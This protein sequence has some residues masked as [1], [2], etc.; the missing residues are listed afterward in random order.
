[1]KK[2][3]LNHYI[4]LLLAILLII[5][6]S[7]GIWLYLISLNNPSL[8]D[9]N[10]VIN[11]FLNDDMFQFQDLYIEKLLAGYDVSEAE[12]L[13]TKGIRTAQQGKIKESKEIFDRARGYLKTVSVKRPPDILSGSGVSRLTDNTSPEDYP[14]TVC[15]RDG[16]IWISWLS[17]LDGHGDIIYARYFDGREWSREM[18]VSPEYGE[19]L[20]P[21]IIDEAEGGISI[22]WVDKRDRYW[23]LYGRRYDKNQWEKEEII[24]R[25]ETPILSPAVAVNKRRGGLCIAWQGYRDDGFQIYLKCRDKDKGTW[26]G[27]IL[28]TDKGSNWNP[29]LVFDQEGRLWIGWDGYQEDNYDIY[30]SSFDGKDLSKEINITI[31]P[32]Y[33]M[34]VRLAIG[35]DDQLWIVWERVLPNWN[36]IMSLQKRG[37]FNLRKEVFIC[38]K[39]FGDTS[40]YILDSSL[41]GSRYVESPELLLASDGFP[42]LLFRVFTEGEGGGR[43]WEVYRTSL[44][45]GGW[46]SPVRLFPSDGGSDRA[47]GCIDKN[48]QLWVFWQGDGRRIVKINYNLF[49]GLLLKEEIFFNKVALESPPPWP[50]LSRGRG[51]YVGAGLVPALKKVFSEEI[52]LSVPSPQ[53][54][55]GKGEGLFSEEKYHLFFGDTHVH[56]EISACFMAQDGSLEDKIR[57][58]HDV[59]GADFLSITDHTGAHTDYLW[60]KRKKIDDFFNIDGLFTTLHGYEWSHYYGHQQIIYKGDGPIIRT[61]DRR[62]NTPLELWK[63]LKGIDAIAIPHQPADK[64]F[65]YDWIPYDAELQPVVEI[66]QSHRGGYEYYNGPLS[67]DQMVKGRFVQDVLAKGYK[68]GVV[69]S[70]DHK[71]LGLTGVYAKDLSRDGIYEALK[72]RHCYATTGEKIVL[73]FR[74]DNHLMGEEYRTDSHPIIVVK[75]I[76]TSPLDKVEIIRNNREIY[77]KEEGISTISQ[78][79]FTD[80]EIDQGENFYYIRVT[81][82]DNEMAWSSPIWV[83][84]EASVSTPQP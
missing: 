37:S 57:F 4:L 70:S 84:Y 55:E 63:E 12:G 80:H 38:L 1:M 81:Q 11:T 44:I 82:K 29:S 60:H 14:S 10:L 16:N 18:Q 6:L 74:M 66:F 76:G 39:R 5:L 2:R 62:F 52:Q 28:V 72:K 77:K 34:N 79:K 8:Y 30:L 83:W 26:S 69:G 64:L 7:I 46:S 9:D 59:V 75:V 21:L 32:S 23:T 54:G 24:I 45:D 53:R 73:D 49:W 51:L 31:D 36:Q 68:M 43:Y 19:Y 27:D 40:T 25:G 78:F 48:G 17:Y 35:N 42:I 13:F 56:S 50:H 61:T 15:D 58:Y 65:P 3:P 22:F 71:H 20:Y 33:D 47:S 41:M 67:T